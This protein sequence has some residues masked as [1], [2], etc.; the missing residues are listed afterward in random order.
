MKEQCDKHGCSELLCGCQT[1]ELN[2]GDYFEVLR[3][4]NKVINSLLKIVTVL[5][6]DNKYESE[7]NNLFN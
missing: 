4:K 1:S 3:A 2:D 6:I 7:I 5:D